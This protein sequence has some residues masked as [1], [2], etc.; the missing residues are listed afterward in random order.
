MYRF[1]GG[2]R[3]PEAATSQF[4][5]SCCFSLHDVCATASDKRGADALTSKWRVVLLNRRLPP[6]LV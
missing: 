6:R 4:W 5:F 2:R 1:Q 3:V